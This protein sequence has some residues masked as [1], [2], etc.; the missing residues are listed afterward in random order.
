M[1]A[2][3]YIKAVASKNNKEFQRHFKAVE[4]CLENELS[5]PKETS[6]FFKGTVDGYGDL[7]DF[8]NEYILKY[9]ENGVELPLE[10]IDRDDKNIIKVSDIPE[11]VDEIII[12][13]E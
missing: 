2:T 13:T 5:F 8:K 10:I 3:L 4:F 11:G 7:E 6:L 12:Y 9:I 1:S